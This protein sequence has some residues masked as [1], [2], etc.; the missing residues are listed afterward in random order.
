MLHLIPA[1]L[2]RLLYRVA[3][4]LR[5]L[6]WRVRRP[7]RTSVVVIAFDEHGKV[8]LVRHSYGRAIWALPGGGTN[9]GERPEH[10]AAR[11]IAEEL[12]C[13]L[14]DLIKVVASE[15][16]TA[17]SRETLHVFAAR[18]VGSAI[19]DMREIIAVELA[20]PEDLPS[21]CDRRVRRWIGQAVALRGSDAD[22]SSDS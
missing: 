20:D 7:R 10:A 19:P 22:Q 2:H 1:P 17:G 8:L 18:L 11:E 16:Q 21:P 13:G 5:R 9:R 14:A 4:T 3:D 6:W 15:E 12:G